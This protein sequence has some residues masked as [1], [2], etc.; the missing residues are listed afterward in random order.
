MV[1]Q[2][3]GHVDGVDEA[4]LRTALH[5]AA[6]RSDA[7]IVNTLLDKIPQLQTFRWPVNMMHQAAVA[8]LDDL[9]VAM[10]LAG[11]DIDERNHSYWDSTPAAAV[12]WRGRLS[13]MEFLLSLENKP[14]LSVIDEA[15][16]TALTTAAKRGHPG[17]VELL[18][19]GGADIT[20]VGE[21][22]RSPL[23]IAVHGYHH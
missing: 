22:D 3:L 6:A 7:S 8:G 16:D 15:G 13:A 5:W 11:C 21:D 12:A 4:E 19:Q 18:L 10:M 2:L 9:L 20:A 17:M 14:D 23:Q 1:Q